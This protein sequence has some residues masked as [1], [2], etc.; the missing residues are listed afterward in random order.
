[1]EFVAGYIGPCSGYGGICYDHK[2]A[3]D[4]LSCL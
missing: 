3:D 4:V 1:M 2:V